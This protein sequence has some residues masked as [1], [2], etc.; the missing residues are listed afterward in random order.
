MALTRL[1]LA[2]SKISDFS[3][4]KGL[5]LRELYVDACSSRA[6]VAALAEIPTLER[7]TVPVLAV[8]VEALRKLT[9]LQLLAFNVPRTGLPAATPDE[10][11]KMV[12]LSLRLRA[13]GCLRADV[14][15]RVCGAPRR[16]FARRVLLGRQPPPRPCVE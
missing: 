15:H 4:L 11:W 14:L 16:V 2:G 13:A 5:P 1:S 8:N 6:D 9:K 3:P 7:L 10:F 12:D